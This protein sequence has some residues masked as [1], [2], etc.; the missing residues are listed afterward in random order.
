M[1]DSFARKAGN[2]MQ[3]NTHLLLEEA[4]GAKY[5]AA[6]NWGIECVSKEW[7][8]ACAEKKR[9]MSA[10]DFPL[11]EHVEEGDSEEEE[12][13]KLD[14]EKNTSLGDGLTTATKGPSGSSLCNAEYSKTHREEADDVFQL[15]TASSARQRFVL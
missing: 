8:F 3:A 4:F 1:Q 14:N 7:L 15:P 9:L 10:A 6:C 2:G 12:H 13:D 11:K 5:E